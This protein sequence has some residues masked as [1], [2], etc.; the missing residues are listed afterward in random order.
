MVVAL[1]I[2]G[3]KIINVIMELRLDSGSPFIDLVQK[4]RAESKAKTLCV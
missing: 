4:R 2:L 3:G 1:G